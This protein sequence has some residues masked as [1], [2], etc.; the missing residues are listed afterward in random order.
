MLLWIRSTAGYKI[1]GFEDRRKKSL[2]KECGY[3]LKAEKR[4]A[5]IGYPLESPGEKVDLLRS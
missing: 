5:E 2:A 1:A 3:H 4:K